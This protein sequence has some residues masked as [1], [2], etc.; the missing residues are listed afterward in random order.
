M[1]MADFETPKLPSSLSTFRCK[2]AW[3]IFHLASKKLDKPLV[4][5]LAVSL[6]S[7]WHSFNATQRNGTT[8]LLHSAFER[9]VVCSEEQ[10]KKRT[11]EGKKPRPGRT[12]PWYCQSQ[13]CITST[14]SSLIRRRGYFGEGFLW[15][16][17]TVT[18]DSFLREE[19]CVNRN[20]STKE[21]QMV[22]PRK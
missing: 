13:W 15:W 6:P 22:S 18:S 16:Y 12:K 20:T 3:L 4:Y 14:A 7:V 19:K 1:L 9:R 17:R 21:R 11:C 8:L 10:Y 2:A 5:H